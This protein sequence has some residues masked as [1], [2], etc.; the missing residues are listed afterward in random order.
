MNKKIKLILLGISAAFFIY[1]LIQK[2]IVAVGFYHN[3]M[4]FS[5]KPFISM[6]TYFVILVLH[7]GFYVLIF[8]SKERKFEVTDIEEWWTKWDRV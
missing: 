1:L 7:L 3:P 4:E 6:T 8:D 2:I 5:F